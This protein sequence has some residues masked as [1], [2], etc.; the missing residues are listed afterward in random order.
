MILL[1]S[2]YP[3]GAYL[4]FRSHQRAKMTYS[5]FVR[6]RKWRS[7]VI[8]PANI[9]KF[10]GYVPTLTK[11]TSARFRQT[12]RQLLTQ[13]NT[14]SD[15]LTQG[16]AKSDWFMVHYCRRQRFRSSVYITSKNY[17]WSPKVARGNFPPTVET[18]PGG[19]T[20]GPR[21]HPRDLKFLVINVFDL[22]LKS[23]EICILWFPWD[24]RY[25][26]PGTVSTVGGKLP[27][28][29]LGDHR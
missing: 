18:V 11:S 28:A 20:D 22:I 21:E 19:N 13:G 4:P 24:H 16:N 3:F 5:H 1:P 27:L 6:P 8:Y 29:T 15:W 12:L 7:Y 2:Q 10:R 26:P 9:G 14:K 25:F 23:S 17:Q